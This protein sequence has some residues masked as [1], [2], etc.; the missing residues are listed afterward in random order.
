MVP[1]VFAGSTRGAQVIARGTKG[2]ASVIVVAASVIVVNTKAPYGHR[3]QLMVPKV[4]TGSTRDAQGHCWWHK[5]PKIIT[6]S[7]KGTD[8]HC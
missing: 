6:G 1:K 3:W 5:R 2:T 4:I 7:T 8:S